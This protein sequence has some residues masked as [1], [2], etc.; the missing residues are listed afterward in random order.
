MHR[1]RKGLAHQRCGRSEG[2]KD[3]DG[4]VSISAGGEGGEARLK[5]DPLADLSIRHMHPGHE[6][7]SF[8]NIWPYAVG[9]TVWSSGLTFMAA[10]LWHRT[11]YGCVFAAIFAVPFL[12][13]LSIIIRQR[14]RLWIQLR[15][16]RKSW[17]SGPQ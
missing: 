14:M 5:F 4:R 2:P 12:I 10:G 17:R 6:T 15:E 3:H 13:V 9:I 8:R 1:Q 16:L 7:N 11:W